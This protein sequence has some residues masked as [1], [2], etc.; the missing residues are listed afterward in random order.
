MPT[1][2]D[3]RRDATE[4][5]EALRGLAHASR[6]MEHPAD[7]HPILGE[8]LAGVRSLRQSLDQLA[9]AHLL[10]AATRT[11]TLAIRRSVP[12]K[13]SPP[14]MTSIRQAPCSTASRNASMPL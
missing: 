4:A 2:T 5:S 6:A 8:L 10:I 11:T 13:H 9:T 7:T 14:P 1:Y 12:P 3:P